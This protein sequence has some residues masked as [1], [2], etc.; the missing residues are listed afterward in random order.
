MFEFIFQGSFEEYQFFRE[1][2]LKKIPNTE[3]ILENNHTDEYHLA[4][5]NDNI[6]IFEAGMILSA[7]YSKFGH[8][9]N[10]IFE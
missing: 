5:I 1:Q 3:L 8:L 9:K 10:T 7:C 6:K 2:F 4:M